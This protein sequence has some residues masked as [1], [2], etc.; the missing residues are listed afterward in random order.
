[1]GNKSKLLN[2][3]LILENLLITIVVLILLLKAERFIEKFVEGLSNIYLYFSKNFLLVCNNFLVLF[4]ILLLHAIL[5][6]KIFFYYGKNVKVSEVFKIFIK[7][8]TKRTFSPLGPVSPILNIDHD[9]KTSSLIYFSYAIFIFLGSF[10][11]FIMFFFYKIPIIFFAFVLFYIL[12]LLFLKETFFKNYDLKNYLELIF[13][14]FLLEALSF[15][16][17][18]ISLWVFNNSLDIFSA[19]LVYLIWVLVSTISPFLYGTGAGEM[20]AT[21]VVY[22]LGYNPSLFLLSTIYYRL[23]TTYLPIL[24]ILIP[25]N[26]LK[27]LDK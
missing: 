15:I 14:A 13:L 10:L 5:W 25:Q 8:H 22:Y 21:L 7:I 11:F 23:L 19:L 9:I 16:A 4:L 26:L 2:K 17:F 27:I 24:F 12:I 6:R 3:I 18:L 20:L 1:M